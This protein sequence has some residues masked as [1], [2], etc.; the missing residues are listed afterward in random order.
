MSKQLKYRL[1]QEHTMDCGK[2]ITKFFI[3]KH[4]SFLFYSWWSRNYLDLPIRGFR[5]YIFDD[6]N[7]GL[8]ILKTLNDL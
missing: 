1:L 6:F 4:K 7:D 3:E 5:C 2:F 8:R